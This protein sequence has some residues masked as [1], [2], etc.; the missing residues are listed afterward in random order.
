VS[1]DTLHYV[2]LEHQEKLAPL[3][4]VDRALSAQLNRERHVSFALP[5]Q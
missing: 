2:T 1:G 3:A 5:N 4:S